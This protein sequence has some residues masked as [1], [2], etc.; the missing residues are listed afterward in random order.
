MLM[1]SC[2]VSV[3]SAPCNTQQNKPFALFL[4]PWSNRAVEPTWP[5]LDVTVGQAGLSVVLGETL[6]HCV[7]LS[8]ST[9][10]EV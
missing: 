5:P 6:S 9:V 7:G 1:F 4:W 2:W 10:P 8:G 3:V